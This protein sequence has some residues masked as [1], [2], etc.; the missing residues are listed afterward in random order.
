MVCIGN[1]GRVAHQTACRDILAQ[2]IDRGNSM[3]GRQRDNPRPFGQQELASTPE[4]RA[5]PVLDERCK[6][7]FD[8]AVAADIKDDE[9][10]PN[11]RPAARRSDTNCSVV[12]NL[13]STSTAI[14]APGRNSRKSPSCF[15]AS[16]TEVKLTPVTLPPGRLR[17]ATRP[18]LT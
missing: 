8:F 17:L 4:Q 7:G 14:L 3:S 11:G 13:G 16:S 6:G 12:G 10:L 1:A 15:A 2:E 9:L 5:S 18:T